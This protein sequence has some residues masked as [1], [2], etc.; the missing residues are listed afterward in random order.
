MIGTMRHGSRI[1]AVVGKLLRLK[2]RTLK[3]ACLVFSRGGGQTCWMS[4][5]QGYIFWPARKILPPPLKSSL[6]LWIFLALFK[7]HKDI[8][9]CVL[10]LFSFFLL[11][12]L[13]PFLFSSHPSNSSL[14]FNLDKNK[15]W[16][17]Y[18]SLHP[19][20]LY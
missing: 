15:K 14:F 4:S 12:P 10:S 5:N 20:K 1:I 17:E 9:T 19:M 3:D 6:F 2:P 11:I 8:F 13:F 18:I 7:L 16:P